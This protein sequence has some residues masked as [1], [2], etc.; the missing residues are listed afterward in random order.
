MP[1]DAGWINL[2]QAVA[3]GLLFEGFWQEEHDL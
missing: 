2:Q 1:Y 3:W